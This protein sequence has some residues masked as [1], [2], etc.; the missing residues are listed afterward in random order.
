MNQ[1]SRF[2]S[3]EKI[4]AI[5]DEQLQGLVEA[6]TGRIFDRLENSD[7]DKILDSFRNKLERIEKFKEQWYAA[8]RNAVKQSF[9]AKLHL[10]YTRTR[11]NERLLD[12]EINL[13]QPDGP[14]LAR[15]A[16]RGELLE[17]L[18]RHDPEV[19]MI[20][21]GFL[22]D[23]LKNSAEV[24][25]NVLGWG[26]DGIVT[27]FQQTQH[28]IEPQAGGLLH[29]YTSETYVE[30]RKTSGWRFKEEVRSK[31]LVKAMAETFQEAGAVFRPYAA[32]VLKSMTA[33][34]NLLHRDED[35]RPA[36]LSEY[37]R[38]AEILGLLDVEPAEYAREL[39]EACDGDL[40]AVNVSY[41]VRFGT[42]ELTAAF[43]FSGDPADRDGGTLGKLARNA[44]REFMLRKSAAMNAQDWLPRVGFAYCS[45]RAYE[46][47]KA[48][49][50]KAR[51]KAVVLPA[52]FTGEK[53]DVEVG[54][55]S[56]AVFLVE[57]LFRFEDKLVAALLALDVQVDEARSG[58][59]IRFDALN[60]ALAEVLE[61]AK[62]LGEYDASCFTAILDSLIQIGSGGSARRDSTMLLEVTPRK[63]MLAGQK[64]TRLLAVGP[65][66]SAALAEDAPAEALIT[67]AA[68]AP[69][70]V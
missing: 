45:P 7:L 19:V 11:R 2:D 30:R 29:V 38:L 31:F 20:R 22:N 13:A 28:A 32:D 42:A 59:T 10:A 14:R 52:W 21:Q 44:L 63:G 61:C 55:T 37:L 9:Q 62:D 6:L 48:A 68:G 33:N 26:M 36:E 40:G 56:E 12:V 3:P 23:E 35:T 41:D 69:S 17:L 34:Y 49:T 46:L 18:K 57:R 43:H 53:K 16:A 67:A 5:A 39:Q 70:G 60:R 15:L 51:L 58:K 27:L 47:Y 8:I 24:K 65:K 50:L 1:L 25:I 66:T 64:V 54:L 4:R